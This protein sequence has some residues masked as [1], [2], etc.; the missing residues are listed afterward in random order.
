MV[1]YDV[2][3]PLRTGIVTF[4]GDP[5]FSMSPYFERK[6][7]DPFDLALLSMG[8]HIGTHV[9][10]PAHYLD[11]GATVDQIPLDTLIG[12][13]FILDMRGRKTID[14][15][16]IDKSFPPDAR[17]VLFK[18]DNGPLLFKNEFHEDYVSLTEKGARFLAEKGVCLVGTDYLSIERYKNSGA[19]VHKTLLKTGALIVEGLNLMDIPAGR[20][21]IF[22][23]PLLIQGA[24]GA[25]ARVILRR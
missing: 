15:N 25:P 22:C 14:A 6:K 18:T 23:L 24:D 20:Y 8:T 7:G 2:T 13:A 11:G 21:E 17:R 5:S 12:E 3:V 10:P 16:D 1:L 9:D 19:P 4:P